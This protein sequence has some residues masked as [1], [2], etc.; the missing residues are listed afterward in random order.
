LAS[1]K[2]RGTRRI[3]ERKIPLILSAGVD[4]RLGGNWELVDRHNIG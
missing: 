3:G 2:V 1:N 4:H